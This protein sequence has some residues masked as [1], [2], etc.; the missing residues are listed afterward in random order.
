MGSPFGVGGDLQTYEASLS[1]AKSGTRQ[2]YRLHAGQTLKID[3]ENVQDFRTSRERFP[4]GTIM[5]FRDVM[6]THRRDRCGSTAADHASE[7][8]RRTDSIHEPDGS[9][10]PT[11]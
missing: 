6:L 8:F 9:S 11:R 7:F 5:C 10:S 1:L 3:W 2:S 4:G